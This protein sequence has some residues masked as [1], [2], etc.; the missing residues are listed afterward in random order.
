MTWAVFSLMVFA[1]GVGRAAADSARY[2]L[3]FAGIANVA[4]LENGRW[5]ERKEVT[6][7]AWDAGTDSGLTYTAPD[8]E[9]L[10]REKVR[11]NDSPHFMTGGRRIP[12]GTITLSKQ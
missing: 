2:T 4:L 6:V 8:Q 3:R 5:V 10:P 12:V 1:A 11:L 7:Y 9:T